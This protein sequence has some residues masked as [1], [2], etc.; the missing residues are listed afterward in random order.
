MRKRKPSTFREE[1]EE[2]YPLTVEVP[3]FD[4]FTQIV[5]IFRD[6][7]FIAVC[8]PAILSYVPLVL[9]MLPACLIGFFV[10]GAVAMISKGNTIAAT[11]A[12]LPIALI[13]AGLFAVAYNLIRVGW[14]NIILKL[15]R[16][17]EATF[18]DLALSMPWLVNFLICSFI[19]GITTTLG[20]MCLIVPGVFIAVRTSL[21]PFLVVDK[22]MGPIEALI[23]SNELVTGYSWQICGYLVLLMIANCTLG[24]LPIVQ[25][26][27]VPA[28]MGYFDLVL[29]RI[30]LMRRDN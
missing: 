30:Y 23:K 17:Q 28:V 10:A 4:N 3:F 24:S 11:I 5:P 29:G 1:E 13:G 12:V 14:T 18:G 2:D 15:L 27:A 9:I 7:A 26:V 25:F 8:V 19:I 20:G 6:N 22:N 21:A 16:G